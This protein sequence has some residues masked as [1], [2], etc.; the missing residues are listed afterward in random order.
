M[1]D[2]PKTTFT[3]GNCR[4]YVK[5]PLKK[6]Q[7]S[8]HKN[9]PTVMLIPAPNGMQIT[10]MWPPTQDHMWCAEYQVKLHS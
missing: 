1:S 5:E 7:G 6:N 10:G 8:C 9:C 4:F 2:D 3:C